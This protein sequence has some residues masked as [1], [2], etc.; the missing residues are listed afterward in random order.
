M[1]YT[2]KYKVNSLD[3]DTNNNMRPSLVLRYMQETADHQMRDRK[4]TY[5]DLFSEGKSFII[6]RISIEIYD[7]INMYDEIEVSTW[8]CKEKAAT[9]IRCYMIERNGKLMAKAYSAWTIANRNTGKL[10]KTS[11][12]DISSY[13]IDEPV[14]LSIPTRFRLPPQF[15]YKKVGEKTVKYSD[16]DMNMHMNN[17]NYPNMICDF[18]P[19]IAESII[20]SINLRFMSEGP[21]DQTIEVFMAKGDRPLEEDREAEITYYFKSKVNNKTNIEAEIGIK[22]LQ[23]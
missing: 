15:D 5:I 9:Y 17:T 6:T 16:V 7:Q 3:V 14:R 12:V 13:E 10:C 1:R 4:P 11:E 18:I 20:T 21:I 19:E 22:K 2:E 8:R 23:V